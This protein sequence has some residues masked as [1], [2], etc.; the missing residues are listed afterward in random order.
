M[1]AVA[2]NRP[3]TLEGPSAGTQDAELP[4]QVGVWGPQCEEGRGEPPEGCV[5]G[6]AG[7]RG[8]GKSP[9]VPPSGAPGGQQIL[10]WGRSHDHVHPSGRRRD[11]GCVM[12]SLGK[13]RG[14]VGVSGWLFLVS[15]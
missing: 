7:A 5:P 9:W 3:E 11:T 2:P 13:T 15:F 6:G 12:G 1:T 14:E 10:R 8:P 4:Q